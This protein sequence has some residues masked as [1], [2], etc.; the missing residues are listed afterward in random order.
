MHKI[1]HSLIAKPLI[2]LKHKDVKFERTNECRR[3]FDTLRNALCTKPISQYLIFNK[4]FIL[5]TDCSGKTLSNM[6]KNIY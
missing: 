2:N 6:T 1:L 4:P 3:Y 5:T